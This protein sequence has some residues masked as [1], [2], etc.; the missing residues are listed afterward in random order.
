M[1]IYYKVLRD[2]VSQLYFIGSFFLR[3]EKPQN[4]RITPQNGQNA[5]QIGKLA[6]KMG[7]LTQIREGAVRR[8]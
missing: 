2:E 4:G 8:K 3:V 1:A 6:P 7:E 5:P